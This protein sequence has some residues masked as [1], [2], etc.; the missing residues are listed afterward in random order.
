MLESYIVRIYRGEK[1]SPRNL[2]GIVE[3]VGLEEKRAFTNLDELW[4]ILNSIR[5]GH[6]T[7]KQRT[8]RSKWERRQS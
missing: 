2:V 3:E 1:D 4:T 7:E 8:G 6:G 5:K